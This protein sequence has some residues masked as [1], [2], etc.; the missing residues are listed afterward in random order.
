MSRE[1]GPGHWQ[2]RV[3]GE[4]P[5]G[6][7]PVSAGSSFPETLQQ[8]S[9]SSII[10]LAGYQ[11]AKRIYFVLIRVLPVG[12]KCQC[13]APTPKK[14]LHVEALTPSAMLFRDGAFWKT[15]GVG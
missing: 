10:G 12:T 14:I 15:D 7:G 4:W 8:S 9:A 1:H 11:D 2:A 13:L 3:A 6:S 5:G